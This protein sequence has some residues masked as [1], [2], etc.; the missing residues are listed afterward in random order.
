MSKL[1]VLVVKNRGEDNQFSMEKYNDLICSIYDDIGID[2]T[3]VSS[4]YFFSKINESK[5][6]G[7]IDK[8]LLMPLK[9]MR[10]SRAFDV[11]HIIDHSNAFL[12]PFISNSKTIITC[13]DMIAIR[14]AYDRDDI[15]LTSFGKLLQRFC[16]KG[17]MKANYVLCVSNTT[18]KEY[19]K[20]S[21]KK[22]STVILSCL[23][24]NFT[25]VKKTELMKRL[26]SF[27]L[28][29]KKY[30]FHVGSNLERK[31]RLTIINSFSQSCFSKYGHLVFA[32]QPIDESMK[33]LVKNLGISEKVIDIGR[34]TFL[35]LNALYSGSTA[36]IFPSLSEGFGWPVIEAQAAGTAVI[37]SN[38]ESL[39]EIGSSGTILVNPT[40]EVDIT[41]AIDKVTLDKNFRD[42]LI[43]SGYSNLERYSRDSLVSNMKKFYL[44]L[45]K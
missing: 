28:E 2:Y 45:D 9:L 12:A 38:T 39:N 17:L 22:N 11:V 30:I 41:S 4:P 34:V 7:Y 26:L 44:G 37:C 23:N 32:G 29:N 35:E 20:Y 18:K 13:H 40:S 10:L 33:L 8:L 15:K 5:W 1:R 21:L 24:E 31:N 6:L 36:F 27:N 25:K 19:D 16:L 42:K 3:V 14:S 43:D